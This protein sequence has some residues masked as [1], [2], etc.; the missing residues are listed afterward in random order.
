MSEGSIDKSAKDR[1]VGSFPW[2]LGGDF[3]VSLSLE[4]SSCFNGSQGSTSDMRDFQEFVRSIGIVDHAFEGPRYTWSN[5]QSDTFMARKL[6]RLDQP[7]YSPLKLFKFF[8]FWVKHKDFMNI[9]AESWGKE[10]HGDPNPMLRLF[11]KL[12]RLKAPLRALN[13]AAF[14]QIPERLLHGEFKALQDAEEQF[15]RQKAR[16][17]WI[18]EGDQYTKFFHRTLAVKRSKVTIRALVEVDLARPIS[19][20]EI[21]TALFE[22]GNDKSPGTDGA[23][24]FLDA[25]I[26]WIAACVTSP[27]SSISI[28]GGL[29]GLFKGAKGLR[30]GDPL[31]PYLF[32]IVMNVLSRLLEIA[33]NRLQLNTSESELFAAEV[34]EDELDSMIS[35]HWVQGSRLLVRYLGLPPVARKL[36]I[37]DCKALIEKIVAKI[38][39]WSCSYVIISVERLV[40]GSKS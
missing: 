24:N 29:V 19:N 1:Q 9:V 22:Q 14:G 38:N 21:K 25:L 23:L 16:V 4:E 12:K 28:N 26:G 18:R 34:L 20:A 2:I 35:D 39:H 27:N 10:V 30:Q 6:D 33:A 36:S 13:V 37:P 15:Y 7:V 40:R 11:I 31:S 3:N 5:H 17:H 8:N 32:A